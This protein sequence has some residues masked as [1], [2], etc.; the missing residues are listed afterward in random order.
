MKAAL[1]T[2][3]L[4]YAYDW[5]VE[6]GIQIVI[7]SLTNDLTPSEQSSHQISEDGSA[8]PTQSVWT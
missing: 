1:A 3:L 2:Y 5:A 4:A 7:S 6:R 8:N